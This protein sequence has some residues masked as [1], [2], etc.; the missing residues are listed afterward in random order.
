MGLDNPR[1]KA[2]NTVADSPD[3]N[4][5]HRW[6]INRKGGDEGQ[7][8]DVEASPGDWSSMHFSKQNW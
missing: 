3:Y 7:I 8:D 2:G 6:R 4:T 1:N 5:I